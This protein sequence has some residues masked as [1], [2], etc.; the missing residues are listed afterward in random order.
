MEENDRIGFIG[1]GQMALA[2]AGGFVLAEKFSRENVF[3]YD[4]SQEALAQFKRLIN[5]TICST[6]TEVLE[7]AD[8]IFLCVKPQHMEVVVD[9]IHSW[10]GNL[11]DKLFVTIAAGLPITYFEEKIDRNIRLVRV[12]P[13]TPC[14]VGEAA[15]G[16]SPSSCASAHD[17]GLVQELLETVGVAFQV[18]ENLLDAVT[19]LS[20]S[21][22]AYVF[23]IIEAL[24][25][26]GV[27]MGLPR[28]VA[29]ILAAQTLKGAATMLLK[30]GEHPGFLKDRVTSPAG[31]TIA[32]VAAMEEYR[33]R[34]AM[35]AAVEAAT[36]RSAELGKR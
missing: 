22:P 9:Q 11:T 16:F 36:K 29:T 10:N 18:P 4:I 34:A 17:A 1:T 3:G 15:S 20:G 27:K 31:T 21:G 24:S 14:L 30:T 12:M 2:L 35:I 8:L 26:G 13:N 7:H 25:D 19:G 28:K 33:V 6:I 5:G 32:G 23:Q